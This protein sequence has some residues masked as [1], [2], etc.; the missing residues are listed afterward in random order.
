MKET[1]I[2]GT[3]GATFLFNVIVSVI[4]PRLLLLEDPESID[5][6]AIVIKCAVSVH[7][8][9]DSK[10]N[11]LTAETIHISLQTLEI[12]ALTGLTHGRPQQISKKF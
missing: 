11:A 2:A 1:Q 8:C 6:R 10:V 3:A 12:F 7:Y 9:N 4:S 5:S